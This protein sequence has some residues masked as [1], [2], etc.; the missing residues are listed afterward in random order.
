MVLGC[1]IHLQ[2]NQA[3]IH[4]IGA[5]MSQKSGGLVALKT[6][7]N[8]RF[9]S[10]GGSTEQRASHMKYCGSRLVRISEMGTAN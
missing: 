7:Y 8:V 9:N 1:H 5:K 3:K 10:P 2:T 6:M 4:N